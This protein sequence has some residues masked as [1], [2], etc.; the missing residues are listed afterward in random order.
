MIGDILFY[1]NTNKQL[2]D[3]IIK[4]YEVFTT[5]AP[6]PFV[7]CAV[8]VEDGNKIEAI[9]SGVV[10]SPVNN[11]RVFARYH[12]DRLM[13]LDKGLVWLKKQVGGPYGWGD[14]ADIIL[15][16]P[17]FECH[18]DCSDLCASFLYYA[19]DSHMRTFI[20]PHL[21]TPQDLAEALGVQ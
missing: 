5:H 9:F 14:I 10:L 18:Y 11:S 13:A 7:H 1:R 6:D 4:L 20:N 19:G 21:L 8:E 2:P 16:H 17:V 3:E 15:A 12:P